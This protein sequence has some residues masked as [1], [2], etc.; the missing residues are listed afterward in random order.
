M[1]KLIALLLTFAMMAFGVTAFAEA[2]AAGRMVLSPDGILSIQM[3]SE[4]WHEVYDANCWFAVGDGT[5]IITISHQ[6]N[7]EQLPAV[8]V[9]DT[10]YGAVYQAIISTRNEVFCVKGCA[11]SEDDQETLMKAIGSIQILKKGTK[12]A[13]QG[14]DPF[15]GTAFGLRPINQLYYCTSDVLVVRKGWTYESEKAGYLSSGNAVMVNGAVTLNGVDTGWYQIQF[16]NGVAYTTSQY[17]S[18]NAQAGRT[19]NPGTGNGR[20][21]GTSSSGDRGTGTNANQQVQQQSEAAASQPFTVYPKKGASVVIWRVSNGHYTDA[22]GN[23]YTQTPKGLY[24]RENNDTTYSA[25]PDYWNYDDD[26]EVEDESEKA[27]S[28]PFTVYP[29]HGSSVRIHRTGSGQYEDEQGN[30]YY[31]TANGLYVREDTNV[32]YSTNPDE[33]NLDD[34]LEEQDALEEIERNAQDKTEG[35]MPE[36]DLDENQEAE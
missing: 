12:A 31:Q 11:V 8:S 20:N 6:S 33:W 26:L 34:E 23:D 32:T 19:A 13:I 35:E 9:A 15:A 7:G 21:S 27:A 30:K 36:E 2:P 16:N 28:Q 14:D 5:N 29:K 22:N 17:L 24:Y 1:K 18:P 25:D 10:Q 4:S 3:P